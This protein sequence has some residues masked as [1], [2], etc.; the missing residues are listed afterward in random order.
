M[1]I[2]LPALVAAIVPV[3]AGAEGLPM[4]MYRSDGA[5]E[6]MEERIYGVDGTHITAQR[7]AIPVTVELRRPGGPVPTLDEY[8]AVADQV[9]TCDEGYVEGESPRIEGDRLV[10]TFTCMLPPG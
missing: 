3:L 5:P 6:M 7:M 10:V 4:R 8:Y 1:K 2:I 9:A